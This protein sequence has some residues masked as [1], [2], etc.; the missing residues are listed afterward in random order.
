[1][2]K[3]VQCF[4]LSSALFNIAPTHPP[5]PSQKRHPDPQ[6]T[7]STIATYLGSLTHHWR[8]EWL[9]GSHGNNLCLCMCV[10]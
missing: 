6:D 5:D 3:D 10:Q 9:F 1:M 4:H 7:H 2:I 8:V